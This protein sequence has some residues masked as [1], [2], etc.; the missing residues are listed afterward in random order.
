MTTY[1]ISCIIILLM[2]YPNIINELM[3]IV[4]RR[5]LHLPAFKD[6][7]LIP[8][9]VKCVEGMGMHTPTAVQH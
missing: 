5:R 7:G 2:P 1:Q 3:M 6:Y 8:S 9:L 4:L